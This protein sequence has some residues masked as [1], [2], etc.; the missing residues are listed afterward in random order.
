MIMDSIFKAA[1]AALILAVGL[2]GSA[3]AGAFE[4]GMDAAESG[5]YETALR[6]WRPLADQGNAT[7][8]NLLGQ[9]YRQGTGAPQDY[10]AAMSWY[11]KAADQGNASAQFNLGFMHFNGLGVPSDY[12]AAMS[13]YRRAADQGNTAAQLDL[14]VM[15]LQGKGAPQDHVSAYMW[16]NLAAA[17]VPAVEFPNVAAAYRDEVA[18][19]MTPA[20][21]AEAQRLAREWKPK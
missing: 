13:W 3:V 18:A 16:F 19:K 20:Q 9:M 10:A 15:Y 17:A 21:I 11:Q 7:V 12:A 14:G 1:V 8:Q 4:D 6:L 2:A 5:D